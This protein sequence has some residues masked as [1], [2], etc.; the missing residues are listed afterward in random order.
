MHFHHYSLLALAEALNQQHQ[1][2][3]ILACFT[4]N[5]DELVFELESGV[6]RVGCHTPL[7]YLVPFPEF[8]RAKRNVVDLFPEVLELKVEEFRV[9]PQERIMIMALTEGHEFIFKLHGPASNAIL[10]QKQ[11][12]VALFKQQQNEDFELKIEAGAW[13][14]EGLAATPAAD[15]SSVLYALRNISPI[16]E[17]KFAR[18]VLAR[19]SAGSEFE[20]VVRALIAEAKSDRWYLR[21]EQNRVRFMLFDEPGEEGSVLVEGIIPALQLFMRAYYQYSSYRQMYSATEKAIS[22]PYQKLKR[23]YESYRKN[24]HVLET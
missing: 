4:Q 7:T 13:H 18:A 14:E 17:R 11:E 5:K 21:K 8:A 23:N 10:R 20:G 22:K 3:K 15:E 16:F 12:V 24:I 6:L 19:M 1:G 2:E 9:V